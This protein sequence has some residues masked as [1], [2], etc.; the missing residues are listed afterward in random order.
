M[1]FQRNTGSE[2]ILFNRHQFCR[3]GAKAAA[4]V[5]VE[6]AKRKLLRRVDVLEALLDGQP[7]D[8][9][10]PFVLGPDQQVGSIL[11]HDK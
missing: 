10:K 8:L 11:L 3:P 9:G 4:Q 2:Q 6:A 5:E 1:Q 7:P